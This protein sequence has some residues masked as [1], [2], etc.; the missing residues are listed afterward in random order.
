MELSDYRSPSQLNTQADKPFQKTAS[1]GLILWGAESPHLLLN[2]TGMKA[3]SMLQ[4][5]INAL[6]D[7]VL[8]VV[9]TQISNSSAFLQMCNPNENSYC[10]GELSYWNRTFL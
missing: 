10:T 5:M 1:K 4:E 2:T 7:W 6:E 9:P 8:K 3:D